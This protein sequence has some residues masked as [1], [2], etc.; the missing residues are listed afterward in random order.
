MPYVDLC[1]ANEEDASDVF[2]I[3]PRNTD[4]VNG[5][6]DRDGYVDVAGK[7]YDRFGCKKV[8]VTLRSSISASINKWSGMLYDDGSAYFA[9]EYTMQIVDRVGGG[10]SFAAGLIYSLCSGYDPQK[11]IDFAVASS[12]LKHSIEHDFN[13]VTVNEVE[14]LA[15]GNASGR[16]QR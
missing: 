12:C 3:V 9:P 6:L 14:S 13:L 2:G 15:S 11:A 7:I 16:V 8:A 4:L 10:D 5:K 1:I